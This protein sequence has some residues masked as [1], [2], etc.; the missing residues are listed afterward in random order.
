[1]SFRNCCFTLNNWT[2]EEF[3]SL[4]S[5][6]Q[7]RYMVIGKEVGE[8]GTPHLQ[9]Y[10][11]FTNSKKL[12]T[13][14]KI[15][16]RIHWE[17]R[18]G[19]AKQ[20]STYCKKDNDFIEVGE[21]SQQGKRSDLD[22]VV[23]M[24]EKGSSSA[25]IADTFPKSYLM[26]GNGIERLR[27]AKYT[28]RSEPP[29]VTWLWGK[30]GTGKTRTAVESHSSFYIKDGTMWWNGYEQQEAIVID[31]FDGRW[32]YRD[33]LR[34]LDR[35]PYQGQFKG[36]Y[37]KINSP[38]IYITCEFPPEHF[39]ADNELAQVTRR[40]TSVKELVTEAAE[41]EVAGNTSQPPS[42]FDL[43]KMKD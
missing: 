25:E 28:D 1:M 8:E 37:L 41:A 3:D 17:R 30:T 23:E 34:L 39:W 18:F 9:G 40:L 13:L 15:N 2:E 38:F 11:E 33:F 21:M 31:D 26:Y 42:W 43:L 19:T 7:V 16:S 14:K 22:D 29:C 20:A 6:S 12:V 4:K 32:P 35:Y 36:G 24:V 5:M 27:A 10:V